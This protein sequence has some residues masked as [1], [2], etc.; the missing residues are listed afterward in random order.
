M[1]TMQKIKLQHYVPRFYLRNFSKLLDKNYIIQCFDKEKNKQ[2]ETIIENVGCEKFFYDSKEDTVQSVEKNL[3]KLE[4]MFN[5]SILNLIK[6]KDLSKLPINEKF[7]L[8]LFI[9]IQFLRSKERREGI[10]SKL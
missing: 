3:A 2:F 4:G 1:R 7:M 9:A 5:N 10:M 6:L 8:S